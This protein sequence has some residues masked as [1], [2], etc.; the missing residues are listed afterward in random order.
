MANK[1]TIVWFR[2]DLRLA[3][4][5]ALNAAIKRGRHRD[6]LEGRAQLIAVSHGA[7]APMRCRYIARRIRIEIGQTRKGSNFARMHINHDTPACLCRE[8]LNGACE[9]LLKDLLGHKVDGKPR[10][11]FKNDAPVRVDGN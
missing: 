1:P 7:V 3:D 2:L 8:G 9:L 11:S 4:Q 10:Y 6:R 5:P